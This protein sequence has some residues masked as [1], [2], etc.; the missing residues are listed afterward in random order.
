MSNTTK[1]RPYWVRANDP[2]E[3][4]KP[5]HGCTNPWYVKAHGIDCCDIDEPQ[6]ATGSKICQ[7]MISSEKLSRYRWSRGPTKA[8][9]RI[10]Y[11][12]PERRQQRESTHKATRAH[13]AGQ[14]VD[15]EG[16]DHRHAP[17]RGGYWD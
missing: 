8:E 2:A 13:R 3:R 9:R 12:K 7:Y 10:E 6:T 5:Y 16:T 11:W 17:I 4:G 15:I 1:D 14:L